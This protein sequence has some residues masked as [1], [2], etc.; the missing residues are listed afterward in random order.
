MSVPLTNLNCCLGRP[1]SFSLDRPHAGCPAHFDAFHS[2]GGGN[3]IKSRVDLNGNII[4]CDIHETD[5]SRLVDG[6]RRRYG[7]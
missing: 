4:S 3:Y 1:A 6:I 7:G 2:I 5:L